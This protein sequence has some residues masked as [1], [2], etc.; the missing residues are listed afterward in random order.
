MW[1]SAEVV[2]PRRDAPRVRLHDPALQAPVSGN[3]ASAKP[4]V[5]RYDD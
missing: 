3:V 1:R 5:N 4:N 2:E